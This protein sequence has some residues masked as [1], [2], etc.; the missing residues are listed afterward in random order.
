MNG[1]HIN[2]HL[3]SWVANVY[4]A[5][6]TA[7]TF[8]Q[9]DNEVELANKVSLWPS[10]FA[11][12]TR[13][14][15]WSGGALTNNYYGDVTVRVVSQQ[16]RVLRDFWEMRG[17]GRVLGPA[18]LTKTA[19]ASASVC[20]TAS[21]ASAVWLQVTICMHVC[22]RSPHEHHSG[23]SHYKCL[24]V[25]VSVYAAVPTYICVCVFPSWKI[26]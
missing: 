18:K 25:C 24:Y 22:P 3:A 13:G 9:T 8:P 4:P 5:T 15:K 12:F 19:A 6:H 21:V 1:S 20:V 7:F 26:K 16:S 2:T 14:H 17:G 23:L 10:V 11:L